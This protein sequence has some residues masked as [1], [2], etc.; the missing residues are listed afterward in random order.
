MGRAVAVTVRQLARDT[1][2]VID[3]VRESDRPVIITRHGIPVAAIHPLEID[4]WAPQPLKPTIPGVEEK[5]IELDS[6]DLSG[7][8]KDILRELAEGNVIDDI[9]H[10]LK[11]SIPQLGVDVT[12]L[13]LAGLVSSSFGGRY[14]LTKTGRRV[15]EMLWSPNGPAEG[16]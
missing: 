5:A 16:P 1:S 13:E 9:A 12:G 15:V 7:L 6:F 2:R 4:P 3:K 8:R 14:R 10:K 11:A